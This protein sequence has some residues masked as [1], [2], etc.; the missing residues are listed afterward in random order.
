MD[1][2]KKLKFFIVKNEQNDYNIISKVNDIDAKLSNIYVYANE[3]GLF[4]K[5]EYIEMYGAYLHNAFPCYEKI[6]I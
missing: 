4:P 2:H 6:A 5:M 3:F 1:S